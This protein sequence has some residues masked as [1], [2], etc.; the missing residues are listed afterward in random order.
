MNATILLWQKQMKKAL[1]H[2][3]EIVGML[4]QPMLWVML[5]GI[6]MVGFLSRRNMILM[7]LAV[8]MMLQGVS[9]SLVAWGRFHNDLGGQMLGVR[10]AVTGDIA[11]PDIRAIG[12]DIV[13]H[14]GGYAGGVYRAFL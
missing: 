7:F 5:F 6:G 10:P 12:G 2:P 3:E 9:V 8:E 1:V 14:F 11:V 13:H 4:I